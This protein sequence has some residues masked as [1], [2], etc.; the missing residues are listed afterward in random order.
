[1]KL[2]QFAVA[3][4]MFSAIIV[5]GLLVVDDVNNNYADHRKQMRGLYYKLLIQG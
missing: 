1:M 3:V 5:M 2:D 4:L